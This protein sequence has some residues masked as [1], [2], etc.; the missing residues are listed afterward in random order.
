MLFQEEASAVEFRLRLLFQEQLL[1]RLNSYVPYKGQS[2]NR[3]RNANILE[4][5]CPPVAMLQN[6]S[7]CEILLL[8]IFVTLLESLSLQQAYCIP[9]ASRTTC[10]LIVG[11][12][13]TQS[14]EF[15][16]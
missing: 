6:F 3:Q 11:R 12:G 8:N 5:V 13:I 14:W 7:T 4:H 9:A 10:R 2:R 15:N 1:S 16:P